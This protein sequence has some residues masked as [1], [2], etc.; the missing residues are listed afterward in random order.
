MSINGHHRVRAFTGPD[1]EQRAERAGNWLKALVR[2]QRA[3]G[4][5]MKRG[6]TLEKAQG[7]GMNPTGGFPCAR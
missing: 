6:I 2:D 1:S 5:C 7:E 3:V 4:W